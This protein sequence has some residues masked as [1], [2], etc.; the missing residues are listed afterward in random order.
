MTGHIPIVCTSEWRLRGEVSEVAIFRRTLTVSQVRAFASG[1][2]QDGLLAH[3]PMTE[4]GGDVVHDV[5]SGWD[6]VGS[7][8]ADTMV[9]WVARTVRRLVTF[10]WLVNITL[11][12]PITQLLAIS[13]QT[14]VSQVTIIHGSSKIYLRKSSNYLS[15]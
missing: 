14:V 7:P 2:F 11:N 8:L 3:W 13:Q 5:V 15:V 6:L 4:C 9:E 1:E 12:V 10:N